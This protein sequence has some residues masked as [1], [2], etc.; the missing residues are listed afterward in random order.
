MENQGEPYENQGERNE[1]VISDLPEEKSITKPTESEPVNV[2]L[3]E[4][5]DDPSEEQ[6]KKQVNDIVVNDITIPVSEEHEEVSRVSEVG[7]ITY[8]N[9]DILGERGVNDEE[10][11]KKMLT[12]LE[13]ININV[14]KTD[15]LS[16]ADPK[17]GSE[18]QLVSELP[19]SDNS[20][21]K[22]DNIFGL[23]TIKVDAVEGAEGAKV[24][25]AEEAKVEGAEGAKVEGA[26]GAK[27]EGAGEAKVEGAGE[28]KVEG[29][30]EAKVEGAGEAKT[31]PMESK[32]KEI[33]NIDSA[34]IDETSSLANFFNDMKQ[35]VEEKGI[36][37]ENSNSFTLFE[38]A[39]E[40]G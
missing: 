22:L 10:K 13:P 8:D 11:V 19:I 14:I 20:S 4:S 32:P 12:N 39:S 9:A 40:N 24:E 15:T 16:E 1:L 34:D 3:C 17:P 5:K 7:E 23:E 30:G 28:A 2:Y 29:A 36:K 21:F 31:E 37:V 35:V 25:G 18:P 27:V 33:I 38:D 6:I 26:E